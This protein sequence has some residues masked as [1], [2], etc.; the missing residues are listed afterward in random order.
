MNNK[1]WGVKVDVATPK[2][3]FCGRGS[4]LQASEEG[5][6]KWQSGTLIQFAL[7]ELTD[8]ER[9]MLMTGTHPV[10]WDE[11]MIEKKVYE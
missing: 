2:C 1:S 11:N 8:D 3:F 7:P 4:V 9:E 6:K 5:F 10:C